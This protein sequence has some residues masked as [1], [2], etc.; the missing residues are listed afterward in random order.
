MRQ[1][2]EQARQEVQSAVTSTLAWADTSER[3]SFEVF[4][5]RL[6]TLMLALGRA[7]V[8]LFLARQAARPRSVEYRRS[9]RTYRL[10]DRRVSPLGTRFGKVECDRPVGR[11]VGDRRAT[12]DLLVDRELALCSG[13]SL[14][15]VTGV[16]RLV[17]QMAFGVARET[18]WEIYAWAPSPR[19]VLRMVDAVG[20]RARGFLEQAAVPAD[21]GALLFI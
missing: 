15:V 20:A 18:Y 12:A 5:S 4:E 16:T 1:S 21:D 13:F 9:G 17:A 10:D 19:A 7:L 2:I 3:R 11:Q 8:R 14:G 6:W